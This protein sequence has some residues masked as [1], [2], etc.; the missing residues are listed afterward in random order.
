MKAQVI[1]TF[2]VTLVSDDLGVNEEITKEQFTEE[3]M[4]RVGDVELSI[5][6]NF[7]D[8]YVEIIDT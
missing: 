7:E 1:L 2:L 5:N 4:K 6:Q 3:I 8:I